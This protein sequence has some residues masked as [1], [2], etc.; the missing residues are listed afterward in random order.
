MPKQ[1][2]LALHGAC[3]PMASS[4]GLEAMGM[5]ALRSAVAG[6][7]VGGSCRMSGCRGLSKHGQRCS[8]TAV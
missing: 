8:V 4:T 2:V 3:M 6:S 1:H 7:P 5:H